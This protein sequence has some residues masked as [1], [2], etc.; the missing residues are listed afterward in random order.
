MKPSLTA[1]VSINYAE[2]HVLPCPYCWINSMDLNSA[3]LFRVHQANHYTERSYVIGTEH[4]KN[5]TKKP[6]KVHRNLLLKS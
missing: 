4:G 6:G 2:Q 5:D 1:Q 3:E